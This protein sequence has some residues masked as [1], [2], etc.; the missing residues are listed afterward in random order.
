MNKKEMLIEYAKE[1]AAHCDEQEECTEK[2]A[3]YTDHGDDVCLFRDTTIPCY[4]K[5]ETIEEN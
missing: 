4:W 5:F 2:C 3:F 1:I